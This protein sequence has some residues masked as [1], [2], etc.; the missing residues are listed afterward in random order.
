MR[1][2]KSAMIERFCASFITL[3]A[4]E[5]TRGYLHNFP[6]PYGIDRRHRKGVNTEAY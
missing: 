5:F 3:A 6:K 2:N 4:Q 1:T